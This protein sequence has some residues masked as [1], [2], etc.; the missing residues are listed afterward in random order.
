MGTLYPRLL[1]DAAGRIWK[2][3]VRDGARPPGPGTAPS[4][5]HVIFAATGGSRV[6]T[7]ALT[8]VR[9]AILRIAEQTGLSNSAT[10]ATRLSFDV[11]VARFLHQELDLD[12]GEASQPAVWTYFGLVLVPDVC[13]W[14]YPR[15]SD[16][17]Y[18]SERFRCVDVSRHTLSRTWLRAHLLYDKDAAEPYELLDVLGEADMVQIITR[19]GDIGATASLA[20]AIV[21]ADAQDN[22]LRADRVPNRRVFRDSLKRL[23]RL[24]AFIDFENLTPDEQ[25]AFVMEQR[26]ASRQA[27]VRLSP[28]AI[29]Q[30]LG[31]QTEFDSN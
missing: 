28:A 24:S 23:L 31:E 1:P 15:R 25:L 9:N 8:D 14:R 11:A 27:L 16:G 10:I 2:D 29:D 6:T 17:T 3:M 5:E 18:N 30:H 19:R 26:A 4:L 22:A 7:A 12:P 20:R 21:R 13:E